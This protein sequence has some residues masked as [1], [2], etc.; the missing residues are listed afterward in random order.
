M[1]ALNMTSPTYYYL[2]TG[3]VG[4][5]P[6]GTLP[7]FAIPCTTEQYQNPSQYFINSATNPPSIQ[8]ISSASALTLAQAKQIMDLSLDCENAIFAG[9]TSNALG[10]KFLYPSKTNDQT[11]MLSSLLAAV[12]S[13]LFDADPWAPN[14]SVVEGQTVWINKQLYVVTNN[15]ITGAEMPEWPQ[16]AVSPVLDGSAQWTLWTTPFWCADM[17][18]SPPT[19][20]WRNHSARQMWQAGKDA[21]S[22]V[23]N[24][25]GLNAYLGAAVLGA[26][27]ITAVEAIQWP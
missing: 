8:P 15:G 5:T 16:N 18:Q 10:S 24:N 23:L 17:S 7:E 21:K 4:L 20:A 6:D 1:P 11:N 12:C 14:T 9:Y 22:S 3:G 2:I 25:M 19:W 27:S 13:I 26:L